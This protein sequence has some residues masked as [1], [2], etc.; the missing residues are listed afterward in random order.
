MADQNTISGK[1]SSESTDEGRGLKFYM[2]LFLGGFAALILLI[3]LIGVGLAVIADP[4]PT[5][6]RVSLL[7]DIFIIVMALE[8]IV[9]IVALAALIVQFARLINLLQNEIKPILDNAQEATDTAKGTAKFVGSNVTE[10]IVRS[11]AFLAG[12][13]VFVREIGGIR[14]AIR[15]SRNGALKEYDEDGE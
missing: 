5:S 12:F 10:P 13:A 1:T 4:G 15:P 8:V 11:Q 6:E 7:R 3:F 9:I 14:R 2:L